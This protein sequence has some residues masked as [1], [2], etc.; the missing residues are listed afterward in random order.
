MYE[1]QIHIINTHAIIL[2]IARQHEM[3]SKSKKYRDVHFTDSG[4]KIMG[5]RI[6]QQILKENDFRLGEN[7]VIYN[8]PGGCA[9]TKLLIL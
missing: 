2:P 4:Y 7:F 8:L 3:T 9:H 6:A 5:Q 1:R